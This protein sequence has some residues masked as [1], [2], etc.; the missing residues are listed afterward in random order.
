MTSCL[1]GCVMFNGVAVADRFADDVGGVGDVQVLGVEVDQVVAVVAET[2][3]DGFAGVQGRRQRRA[4]SG[5]DQRDTVRGGH[6]DA[7]VGWG[8]SALTGSTSVRAIGQASAKLFSSFAGE[9]GLD[10]PSSSVGVR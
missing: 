6:Y 2:E 5:A 8:A 7:P 10:P 1:Q 4:D 9:L 3:L